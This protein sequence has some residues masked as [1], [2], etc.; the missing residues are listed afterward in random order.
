MHRTSCVLLTGS[1]Y[2]SCEWP[3]NIVPTARYD[4]T[5][6]TTALLSAPGSVRL[7]P[8]RLMAS[9]VPATHATIH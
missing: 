2:E 9:S 7:T 5:Y 6:S 8:T 3:Q 1:L 4:D